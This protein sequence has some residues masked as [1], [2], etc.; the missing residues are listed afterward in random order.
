MMFKCQEI[1][2][3]KSKVVASWTNTINARGANVRRIDTCIN[4]QIAMKQEPNHCL[5]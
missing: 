1:I 5:N 2:K 4:T 3:K